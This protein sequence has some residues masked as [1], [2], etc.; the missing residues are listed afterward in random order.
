VAAVGTGGT[1]LGVGE[2]LKEKAPNVKI[3]SVEPAS[4][5]LF[6]VAP[7]IRPYMKKYGIPGIQGWIILEIERRN[8]V[9]EAFLVKDKDAINMAHRLCKEEGLF[10]GMSSGANVHVALKVAKKLGKGKTVVTILPDRRDR[11]L[12]VEHF[13]T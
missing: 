6:K 10:V 12:T 5:P 9:D 4:S 1:L 13:T 7:Q 3:Y 11:Y 8:M 2:A